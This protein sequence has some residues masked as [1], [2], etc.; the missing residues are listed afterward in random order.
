[1]IAGKWT[2]AGIARRDFLIGSA[3]T[4]SG[5]LVGFGAAQP[6][7]ATA[8]FE[9]NAFIRI[10]PAGQIVLVMPSVEMGQGIYTAV[11]MLIAEELEVALDQVALE[12][13]PADPARYAN[14]IL[15]DQIT[16]GSLA[17][18][19]I[20]EPMR[21]AGAAA[22]VM[23][24]SAAAGQ[25]GV[26]PATCRA[27]SGV[28]LHDASGRRA[29]YGELMEAA[30]AQ[31]VPTDVPLKRA[32][33]F[34]VI[35]QPVRRLDSPA[36]VNGTAKFGIDAHPDGLSYAAIAICPHFN[37]TLRSVTDGA[38]LQV[39]GV[40]Q[41]VQTRNAVAV[42]ADNTGSAR[43]G[44]AALTIDWDPGASAG[45]TTGE[46]V[47]RI[48]AAVDGPALPFF[49]DGDVA[50]SEADHGPALE[51]VY[52][53]SILPHSTMEPM[54]CTVHVRADGCEVW[55]GTQIMSRARQVAADVL[56]LPAEKVTVHNHYLG[57]GFGRRLDV[58][59]IIAATEIARQVEGPVKVTWSREEDMRHDCYRYL[60]YS[61]VTA[62]LGPD[63]L[64]QSW[65]HRVIGPS[66]MAR[67]MPAFTKDGIDL[68]SM[69]G[70]ESPYAIPNKFTEFARHEAPEGMLTGN[71]RGVGPTRNVPAIEGV[72]DELAHRA[73]VDPAE[74]RRRLLGKNP[75]LLAVLELAVEKSG[76]SAAVPAG[77]GRGLAVSESFGSFAAMVSEVNVAPDGS[78]AVKRITCAVDCGQVINPD[79]VD[80]QIQSGIVYGL[81]AALYG[82]I[83]VE[84][85]AV[86]EGNFDDA[87][88]VRM[89]EMPRI[90]VHIVPSQEPPGG[91][92]ELGTPGVGPS[93]L[94][95]IFV[96]TGTRLRSLPV[97]TAQLR[98]A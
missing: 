78:L 52:R 48:E 29:S 53:L 3:L 59:G 43:K 61:K 22:R 88:V 83:T 64:P 37:G 24:V 45:L 97:D 41:V 89:N 31:P 77:S 57:G 71:W 95:A 80:A 87:P 76:W 12:H 50:Q 38:A 33:E 56:G 42:V 4:A 34:K 94:N 6:A 51:F 1:M 72:I 91:I 20:Y 19:G 44:L 13:A 7:R 23:L 65:R 35:G 60:N 68:D 26:D 30:A 11:A 66:V 2:T 15:G 67:W 14:P 92:G 96:A 28:V 17:I 58:D 21:V 55:T 81:S 40:K 75:R 69:D 63:G 98:R 5:L 54:N 70:A 46:L 90:D 73:G 82:R 47:R 9:P 93:L 74:Y 49:S 27:E 85:G 36:K 16:G 84:N 86:V 39:R 32:S 79:T 8:P 18:R 25:W 62:T 10:P